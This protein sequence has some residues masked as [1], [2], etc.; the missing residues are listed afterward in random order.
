MCVCV[1]CNYNPTIELQICMYTLSTFSKKIHVHPSNISSNLHSVYRGHFC[2]IRIVYYHFKLLGEED[3]FRFRSCCHQDIT[4]ILL[5]DLTS[6]GPGEKLILSYNYK[7]HAA[8]VKITL[9]STALLGI[10]S[11]RRGNS[12]GGGVFFLYSIDT[13]FNSNMSFI[14]R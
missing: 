5:R 9:V 2:V 4:L 12:E 6:C 1:L 3:D 8:A 13:L 14:L 11:D 7:I 10:C